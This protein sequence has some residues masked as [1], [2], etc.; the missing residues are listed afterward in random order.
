MVLEL[1]SS[2]IHKSVAIVREEHLRYINYLLN[3]CTHHTS[4]TVRSIARLVSV[5]FM[6]L[7]L[8]DKGC[9]FTN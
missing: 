5:N 9:S 3:H 8:T 7:C 4:Q 1:L 2:K 6:L